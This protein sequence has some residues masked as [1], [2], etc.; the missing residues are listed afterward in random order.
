MR[1]NARRFIGT[2]I[3]LNAFTYI[4]YVNGHPY[5]GLIGS[6]LFIFIFC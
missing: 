6:F 1:I 4:G 2:L 5:L 3:L